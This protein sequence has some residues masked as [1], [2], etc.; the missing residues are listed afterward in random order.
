MIDAIKGREN[1]M[2]KQIET[3]NNRRDN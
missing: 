3:E 1:V 2:R